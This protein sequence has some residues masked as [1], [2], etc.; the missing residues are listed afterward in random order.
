MENNSRS[1]WQI[2][3][4]KAADDAYQAGFAAGCKVGVSQILQAAQAALAGLGAAAPSAVIAFDAPQVAHPSLRSTMSVQPGRALPGSV[5]QLVRQFVLSAPGP[6]TERQLGS[7]HPEINRSSRY[8]A[9]R[10]LAS[11]GVIA[12]QGDAWVPASKSAGNPGGGTP[13]QA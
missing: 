5:K 12:K 10:N 7:L 11:D 3:A 4:V 6:V 8:M 1:S 2:L 13:G 9:F